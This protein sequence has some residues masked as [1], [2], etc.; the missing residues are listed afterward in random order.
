MDVYVDLEETDEKQ[1]ERNQRDE[2]LGNEHFMEGTLAEISAG[3]LLQARARMCDSKVDSPKDK[4]VS[5]M[6]K[7]LALGK[8]A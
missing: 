6:R 3:F 4:I 7:R 1:K 8:S 5:E 2:H